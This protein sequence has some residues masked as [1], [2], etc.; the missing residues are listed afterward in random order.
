M[1]FD[2]KITSWERITVDSDK[3][4]EVLKGIKEGKITDSNDI[5]NMD[6]N[7]ETETILE[8]QEQMS[9]SENGGQSTI[10]VLDSKGETI[11]TNESKKQPLYYVVEKDL[12][13][14]DGFEEATG[15]KNIQLYLIESNLPTVFGNVKTTNDINSEE[16]IKEY[17]EDKD[18]N[19]D[20]YELKIL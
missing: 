2:F 20:E 19:I 12:Q 1:K 5:F 8:V 11:F 9:V 3:E 15:N 18:L 10:E 13:D 17:F 4:E 14:I 6:L 16:A 7:A